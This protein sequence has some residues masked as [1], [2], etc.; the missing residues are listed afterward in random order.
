[1][2]TKRTKRN[3]MQIRTSAYKHKSLKSLYKNLP[4]IEIKQFFPLTFFINYE[5]GRPSFDLS[6]PHEKSETNSIL[7]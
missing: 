5:T 7:R 2:K 4:Y 3:I 6:P 1:M